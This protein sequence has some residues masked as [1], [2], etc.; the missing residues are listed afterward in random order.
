MWNSQRIAEI[1]GAECLGDPNVPVFGCV[2]DSRQARGGEIFFALV[3]EKVDGHDYIEVAWK[4]GANLAIAEKTKMKDRTKLNVPEG[5]ALILVESGLSA[6]QELAKA[7]RMELGV[8]VVAI[9]GSNGKTTTKDMIATVLAQK[10]RVHKNK[11]NQNNELG[12]P[13]TLLNA[14]EKTEVLVIEMGM[15]G[16]GQIKALCDFVHPDTGV[17]T[18]IGTTHMELLGSQENIAKAKWELIEALP[19]RGMAILNGEDLWSVKKAE[20]DPHQQFFYG[21][22]GRYHPL[23]IQGTNLEQTGT[24][25]TQFEIAAQ[26]EHAKAYLP[27]PGEHNVLD[28]LSALAVGK[29]YGISLQEGCQGLAELELS[30]MRLELHPGIH[31]SMLL[32]DVYNANPTSMQASLKVLSQ[33][34]SQATLAILGEMYELGEASASG[35]NVVGQAVAQLGITEIITVGTLAEEI[36]QG[37]L[38]SGMAPD[39]VHICSDRESAISQAKLILSSLGN[40]TWVLIKAS[41]GMKMEKVTEALQIS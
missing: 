17:I 19:I 9:T 31:G 40:E 21:I 13:M 33:R 38:E 22:E 6:M 29:V 18:N 12:V 7:W 27:L 28:A 5:K 3:G 1:L 14:P 20:K 11:E 2:I 37:A 32:S 30:K 34:S 8:K 39:R 4:N 23:N 26:A 35:H 25:G 36:A 16:L 41:R 10:Y 24:L 15:R